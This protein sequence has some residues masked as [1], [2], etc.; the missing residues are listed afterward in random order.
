MK[1]FTKSLIV[2]GAVGTV[3]LGTLTAGAVANAESGTGNGS[4]GPA[5]S[6]VGKIASTFHLDKSKVRQVFD[7]QRSENEAKHE[8]RAGDRL[9]KLVD[10]GVITSAQKSAIESKLAELKTERQSDRGTFRD[11]T[12]AQRKA[13]M[14]QKRSELETWAKQQGLDLSKLMGIFGGPEGHGRH[15]GHGT[16]QEL[17]T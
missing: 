4:G 6:L 17:G 7:Q 9:Q 2:A 3:G 16:P 13:K 5:S 1:A 12:P 8:Q 15:G 11:L 14:D 10:D